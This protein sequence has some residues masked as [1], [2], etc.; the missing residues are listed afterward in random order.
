[1][2]QTS[3][4]VV[5]STGIGKVALSR[6][7][8]GQAPRA[9]HGT[10]WGVKR[11]QTAIDTWRAGALV[12]AVVVVTA[13]WFALAGTAGAVAPPGSVYAFGDN[14][15]GQLGSTANSG[16]VN[17]N[18]TPALV[19]LPGQSGQVTEIA[20]G[21]DHSLALTAS[22]QLYAFGSNHEGELGIP[23]N[24]GSNSPNPTPALVSLPGQSG[25]V[26]QIA[27]GGKDSLAV[28]A[29]GQLYAFGDN[30]Y[31]ELGNATNTGTG[32]PN[33]TPALVVLPGQSGP[34]TQI[35]AGGSHSLALTSSGQLYAFG[36][37]REGQLGRAT[38]SGTEQPNPTPAL[39]ILPGQSGPVTQI[40]AGADHSLVLTSSG[41]LY[42]FGDNFYG[43]LG[44]VTNNGTNNPNLTPAL[45]SLPG[46]SGPVTEIA[47]GEAHSLVLTASG[48]LY[49]FG[50]NGDGELGSATNNGTFH[51]NP[52]P[53]LV[54]LPGQSGQITQIAAGAKQSLAVTSSGQVY[55]FGFNGD[56]ALGSATN[57]GT[58]N[59]NP[60]P[61][62]V[63]LP[64]G[65]MI[66]A[67]ARGP[68]AAHSLALVSDLEITSGSL[69]TGQAGS[70]YSAALGATGGTAPLS[71]SVS[72]LPSGLSLDPASGTLSGTPS[73]AGG[74]TVEVTV[75]DRYGSRAAKSLA[76]AIAPQ[77]APGSGAGAAVVTLSVL[78]IHPSAFTRSGRLVG[79]H[80]VAST[81]ANRR[82]RR[83]T[84]PI[85]LRVGYTLS[86][87]ATVS[88]EIVR[89]VGG[90]RV[91]GRCL[92]PS[93]ASRHHR[94]CTRVLGLRKG[95]TRS[96][97]AGQNS[98]T[99]GAR[100]G[101]HPLSA[102][103]YRLIATP[104]AAGESGAPVSVAFRIVR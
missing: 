54:S 101:G 96:G 66:E 81:R 8:N 90:R 102:G 52:T 6:W 34:V 31:G 10:G 33:P 82:H 78:R 12:G 13:L 93:R 18:P 80:C 55:A 21:T 49:A 99:W 65:T 61:T 15:Y 94:R 59:P 2:S 11:A 47:A 22:G 86:I 69:P 32:D 7:G 36:D 95:F 26:T 41:Q 97:R 28:T 23:T 75:I 17:P 37:N 4:I 57:S 60:T 67:V 42:A 48:Q 88:F 30:L 92:A 43:E 45:V 62:L 83:C 76:L 85:A 79:G 51:P 103:N 39:V 24:S 56:G 84:R 20:A 53:A 100:I 14:N 68:E 89:I 70:P 50:F 71:W 25:P 1:M 46:Q 74:Y 63:N 87:P 35:A 98:F 77:P 64:A 73:A 3:V 9:G 5:D 19:S 38:N 72:G 58:G 27:A 16:T 40:A 44:N 91:G 104:T 29:S